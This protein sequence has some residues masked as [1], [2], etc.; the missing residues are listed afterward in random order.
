MGDR[1]PAPRRDAE[2]RRRNAP[3]HPIVKMG[4]DELR[5]L[6]FE[7][8]LNPEPPAAVEEWHPLVMELWE[9]LQVDPAR[10]WMTSAD[11]MATKIV[12]ET[13]SRDLKPQVV[14]VTEAGD[15]VRAVVPVKG[16]NQTAI[17]KHLASIGVTEAARLRLQKEITLH[18]APPVEADGI[19]VVDIATRRQEEVQ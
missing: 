13:L 19:N 8:D 3:A 4:P 18:P 2:R 17:L 16:A 12:C 14:G 15:V 7:V 10:M 9:A 6:G 1:G 11:W 5:S